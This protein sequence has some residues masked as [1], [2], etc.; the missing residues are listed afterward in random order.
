VSRA[1]PSP[2]FSVGHRRPMDHT[3]VPMTIIAYKDSC[4]PSILYIRILLDPS[5]LTSCSI[6]QPL[7]SGGH[8]ATSFDRFRCV[9]SII[10]CQQQ[11]ETSCWLVCSKHNDRRW[12]LRANIWTNRSR[13]TRQKSA[14]VTLFSMNPTARRA[15]LLM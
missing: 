15:P 14:D 12:S 8:R 7:E 1:A 2:S 11:C 9:L 13:G 6:P 5:S 10:V 3:I 4:L